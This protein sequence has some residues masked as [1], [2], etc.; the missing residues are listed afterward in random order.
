MSKTYPISMKQMGILLKKHPSQVVREL[1]GQYLDDIN[2][3]NKEEI[4]K[5]ISTELKNY[6][7][8]YFLNNTAKYDAK[9]LAYCGKSKKIDKLC[10]EYMEEVDNNSKYTIYRKIS[11]QV[12]WFEVFK[13]STVKYMY[14]PTHHF[15]NVI[16]EQISGISGD[17]LNKCCEYFDLHKSQFIIRENP[18]LYLPFKNVAIHIYYLVQEEK[19]LED[20]RFLFV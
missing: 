20:I 1:C 6:D 2:Y 4:Y 7:K 17:D 14:T 16:K 15:R 12:R 9:V 11:D 18:V 5:A 8:Q 10:S 3:H 13:K 19:V